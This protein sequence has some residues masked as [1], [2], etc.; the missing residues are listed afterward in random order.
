MWP[1]TH[2]IRTTSAD[3]TSP[4]FW[5]VALAAV[6]AGLLLLALQSGFQSL[7]QIL[8]PDA[9]FLPYFTT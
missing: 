9:P 6:A 5:A 2:S 8:P 3:Q 1:A 7:D 4:L